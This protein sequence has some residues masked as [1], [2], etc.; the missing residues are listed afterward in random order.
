MSDVSTNA[1]S[2]RDKINVQSEASQSNVG[3]TEIERECEQFEFSIPTENTPSKF[4]LGFIL[5]VL[6][7]AT[8]AHGLAIQLWYVLRRDTLIDV[9]LSL[10]FGSVFVGLAYY[11]W[12]N[13]LQQIK[14]FNREVMI[15]VMALAGA[16]CAIGICHSATS[17]WHVDNSQSTSVIHDAVQKKGGNP[18]LSHPV[19][20]HSDLN[21]HE[22]LF[23]LI[24]DGFVLHWLIHQEHRLP[25]R[26][27]KQRA[28][29]RNARSTIKHLILPL[30]AP[31]FHVSIATDGSLICSDGEHEGVLSGKDIR[32]DIKT[33]GVIKPYCNWQQILR[34]IEPH[35]ST[36]ESVWVL[37]SN[38]KYDNEPIPNRE[39][40]SHE[41]SEGGS[42]VFAGHAAKM[43]KPYLKDG[44]KIFCCQL[45]TRDRAHGL[46]FQ[47]YFD[48]EQSILKI[49]EKIKTRDAISEED[50]I[51]IDTTGAQKLISIVGAAI[52]FR[53]QALFQYVDTAEPYSVHT[54]DVSFETKPQT[55]V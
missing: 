17:L 18:S 50:A 48:V 2:V 19:S 40:D 28:I 13:R 54:Y 24:I 21:L 5:L 9:T 27:L 8:A 7:A 31:N 46:R 43:I 22:A 47:D 25:G 53:R 42:N 30:T 44:A 45:N 1:T 20:S 33:L 51:M 36:L 34:A 16:M 39:L 52:T 26:L 10:L 32:E 35:L 55:G 37:G 49:I 41:Q 11:F 15:G 29:E 3:S 38:G 12:A 4:P 14:Q 23:W 6:A